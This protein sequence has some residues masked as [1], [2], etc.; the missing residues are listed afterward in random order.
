MFTAQ[1]K[2]DY[3]LKSL[4]RRIINKLPFGKEAYNSI[5]PFLPYPRNFIAKQLPKH[6]VGC[7]IGTYEGAFTKKI[8]QFAKPKHLFLVDPWMAPYSTGSRHDSQE[9]QDIRFSRVQK[10]FEPLIDQGRITLIRKTS[11]DAL[12]N[13]EKNSLDFVYIDGDHS[14]EQVSKDLKN[15]YPVIKPGGM[16]CG[17]DYNEMHPETKRGVD[18]FVKDGNY[19]LLI[20]KDQFIIKKSEK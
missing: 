3:K 15:Y 13:F 8:F 18:D 11:N 17:D 1:H 2:N 14:Y 16:L 7:E 9:I 6:A 5:E 10:M 20:Q 19:D 12:C 4:L